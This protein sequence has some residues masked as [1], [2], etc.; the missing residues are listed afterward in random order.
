MESSAIILNYKSIIREKEVNNSKKT[1]LNSL[2]A[3]M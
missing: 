1:K 3:Y 2:H